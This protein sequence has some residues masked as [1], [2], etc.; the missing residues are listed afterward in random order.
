MQ[1]M[2][3]AEDA[4]LLSGESDSLAVAIFRPTLIYGCGMDKSLSRAARLIRLIGCLPLAGQADGKRQPVH[5]DDLAELAGSWL[6]QSERPSGVWELAGFTTLTYRQMMEQI[7]TALGRKIR[8]LTLT[9]RMMSILTRLVPGV[10]AAMIQRQ[11][12]DL[13]FDDQK[14]RDQL[15]W[16]PRAFRLEAQMLSPPK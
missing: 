5:A 8:L 16:R 7:F 14:A 15:N 11:N 4:I 10:N 13:V 2:K 6:D 1:L 3:A 9:T 12:V